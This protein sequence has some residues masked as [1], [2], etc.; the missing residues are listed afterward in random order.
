MKRVVSPVVLLLAA[1]IVTLP[2]FVLA[3]PQQSTTVSPP[4]VSQAS[5]LAVKR[6]CRKSSVSFENDRL[7]VQTEDCPFDWVLEEISKKAHV[8]I[9]TDEG[10]R[11][12]SADGSGGNGDM[13]DNSIQYQWCVSVLPGSMHT[14]QIR[15]AS[16]LTGGGSGFNNNVFFEGAHFYVDSSSTKGGCTQF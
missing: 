2:S 15:L 7:S 3:Q 5:P 14:V 9:I 1:R 16:S 8:A 13:H 11:S 12:Q 10:L 6:T 4:A